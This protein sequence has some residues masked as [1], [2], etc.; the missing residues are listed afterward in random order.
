MCPCP[1]FWLRLDSFRFLPLS[2][3][4]LL[5]PC[6]FGIL[7]RPFAWLSDFSMSPTTIRSFTVLSLF[8]SSLFGSSDAHSAHSKFHSKR[9]LSISTNL[10]TG[11]SYLGCYTDSVGT[12]TLPGSTYNGNAMTEESCV[13]FCQSHGYPY[14]GTEY[15]GECYCGASLASTGTVASGSDCNV[16][17]PPRCQLAIIS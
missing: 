15:G 16:S 12:R 6:R 4:L 7:C 17:F 5:L 11:W 3:L 10:P 8:V 9:A 2:I 14:A 1:T 13:S